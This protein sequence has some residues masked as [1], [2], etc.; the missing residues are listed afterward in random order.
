MDVL[1]TFPSGTAGVASGNFGVN[2]SQSEGF[3]S[4]VNNTTTDQTFKMRV[5]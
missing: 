1:A 2:I 4:V 5:A 3:I